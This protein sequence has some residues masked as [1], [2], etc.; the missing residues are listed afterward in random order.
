MS[1]SDKPIDLEAVLAT[2]QEVASSKIRVHAKAQ[3]RTALGI[4]HA[5]MTLYPKTTLEELKRVFPDTLNP[6]S[7]VGINFILQGE[8]DEEENEKFEGYFQKDEELI[9]MGDGKKVCVVMMW[10]KPSL[11]R[12]INHVKQFHIVVT[13]FAPITK[14]GVKGG[15]WL[16]YMNGYTPVVA[17]PIIKEKI[18]VKEGKSKIPGWLWI[19]LAILLGLLLFFMLRPKDVVEVEKEVVVEKIIRD[20]VYVKQLEAIQQNFNNVQFYLDK[21]DLK[22][23]AK[24]VLYD[25]EKLM[26]KNTELRVRITGH[27]SAEGDATHNMQL[28]KARAKA[29]VDFLISRGIEAERLEFEGKGSSE[30]IDPTK[31][32]INRRTE[33]EFIN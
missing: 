7:G 8:R 13:E 14:P 5:Y 12:L 27:T 24:F 28:S 21:S 30:P 10:T 11:I 29:A 32:D 26:K 3:N 2:P 18:V 23:E 31:L 1:L 22:D 19:L 25:L 9:T 17:A 4:I 33:F 6:D 16:E 15:F 20:T